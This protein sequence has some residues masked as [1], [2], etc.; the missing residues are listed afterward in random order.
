MT[1]TSASSFIIPTQEQV[2]H[3]VQELGFT[4]GP[5]MLQELSG[6][7][8]NISY[9]C[10]EEQ[11]DEDKAIVVRHARQAGGCRDVARQFW[12]LGEINRVVDRSIVPQALHLGH[13]ALGVAISI[14]EY[15]PGDSR[16]FNSLTRSEITTFAATVVAVHD[17][18][19]FLF[20]AN[21]G[22][23]PNSCGTYADYLQAMYVES[24]HNRLRRLPENAYPKAR[25]LLI[26]GTERLSR[27]M[28]T[29]Q[30]LFKG[31]I[32]SLQHHDLSPGNIRWHN[33][34]PKVFDWNSTHGDRSDELSYIFVNN[35]TTAYFEEQFLAD[36][37]RLS[38]LP[39]NDAVIERLPANKLN[40]QLDDMAWG[41]TMH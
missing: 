37:C 14:E 11:F 38:P 40:N 13:T 30:S 29:H 4:A 9:L 39:D 26:A 16:D 5:P 8:H 35:H 36:Y 18:T 23:P 31:N 27:I 32:F 2:A 28:R 34:H 3:Y 21:S 7:H 17:N 6:G 41:M 15:C 20:S 25:K 33:G 22:E 19:S 1:E 12:R 24:V 10:S